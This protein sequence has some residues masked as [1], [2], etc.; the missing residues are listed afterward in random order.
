MV[1]LT[2]LQP[3]HQGRKEGGEATNCPPAHVA[4]ISERIKI[5]RVCKKFS[6]GTVLKSGPTLR[7]LAS[8]VKDVLPSEKQANVFYKVLVEVSLQ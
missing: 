1:I 8:I 2:L 7:S 4:D 6:I 3:A 5:K